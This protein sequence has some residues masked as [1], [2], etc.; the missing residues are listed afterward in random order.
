MYLLRNGLL[1]SSDFFTAGLLTPKALAASVKLVYS[2]ISDVS[3]FLTVTF[4]PLSAIAA[5]E[6]RLRVSSVSLISLRASDIFLRVSSERILPVAAKDKFCLVSRLT[7]RSLLK[8]S[9]VDSLCLNPNKELA[10]FNILYSGFN[11]SK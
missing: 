2:K 8:N 9:K 6:I 5:W 11:K 10:C 1:V 3:R 7:L 4:T